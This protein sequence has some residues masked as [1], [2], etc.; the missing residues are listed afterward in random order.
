MVKKPNEQWLKLYEVMSYGPK[1]MNQFKNLID[2]AQL[3]IVEDE[4]E[5]ERKRKL[6]IFLKKRRAQ[7]KNN[8]FIDSTADGEVLKIELKNLALNVQ[9][10]NVM[11]R[12]NEFK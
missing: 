6:E 4:Y 5:I 1:K 2:Q 8:Q 12:M 9:Q 11:E 7:S 3:V 10:Q